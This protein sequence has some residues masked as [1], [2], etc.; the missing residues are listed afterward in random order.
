MSTSADDRQN[1]ERR[2]RTEHRVSQAPHGFS[3]R[4]MRRVELQEQTAPTTRFNPSFIRR[5]GIISATGLAIA[6]LLLTLRQSAND[7]ISP[8]VQTASPKIEIPEIPNLPSL[9][10]DQIAL[11]T[12]KMNEPLEKEIN[13]VISDTRQAIQ[14]VASNFIPDNR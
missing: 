2:L 5:L 11:I 14:F 13:L 9:T 10:S 8:V 6:T 7:P 3:E 1:L 4:V 12:A